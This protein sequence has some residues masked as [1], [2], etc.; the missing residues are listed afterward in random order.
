MEGV[1]GGNDLGA[2]G[3]PGQLEGDLVGLGPGVAE[4][5]PGG[6]S[7]P[8]WSTRAS[9]SATPGSV[10]YRFEVWPSVSSWVVTASMTAG[11]RCPRT[12][13]AM[14][15]EQ[16][17]IGLAVDVGDH[18]ALAAGQRQ[19][20]GAVVV[21]HHRLPPLL[22]GLGVA[23]GSLTF[24]PVPSSVNSSTS[25]QCSTRPSTTCALGRRPALPAGRPRSWAP[26]R[27][28]G[29]AAVVSRWRCRSR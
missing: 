3:Q 14:P 20:R 1:L 13:T 27:S 10:A 9:A 12:L 16:I 17:E 18:R 6:P 2:A 26:C 8:R 25:T 5:H 19:R 23:H 4:E 22:H 11:W 28:P 24:V 21:H 15:A 29:S 7:A